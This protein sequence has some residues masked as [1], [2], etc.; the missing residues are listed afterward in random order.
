MTQRRATP[1]IERVLN[2]FLLHVSYDHF[3]TVS[4]LYH[5]VN[6]HSRGAEERCGL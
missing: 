3:L 2:G 4:Q 6:H 5:A 1:P